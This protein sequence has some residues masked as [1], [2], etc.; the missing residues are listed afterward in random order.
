MIRLII[1]D[2]HE[3]F[4]EGLRV[5][6]ETEEDLE[7]VG[8]AADGDEAITMVDDFK[9]DLIVLDV[10]MPGTHGIEAARRI[11]ADN[12]DTRILA[13]SRH[14][15]RRY[16]SEMFKAGAIGY[17][18]KDSAVRELVD[19]IKTVSTGQLYCSPSLV[20]V[21]MRDYTGRLAGEE[22]KLTEREKEVLTLIA[23]GKNSK[24]IAHELNLSSKTVDSHRQRIM[25]KLDIHN[26]VDLTKYAIKEGLIVL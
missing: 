5:L 12:P 14:S 26:V 18:L 20:G 10:Q 11:V 2:D 16:V 9:P 4:R 21:V 17:I 23:E 3:M 1:A 25:K 22:G 6:L 19:A 24:E 15:E 7:I 13:L 8:E